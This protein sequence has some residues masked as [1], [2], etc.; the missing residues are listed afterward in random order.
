MFQIEFA[1][2]E[3]YSK[4]IKTW[5]QAMEYAKSLGEGWRLPTIGELKEAYE[6]NVQGFLSRNY[7]SLSTVG[8]DTS[9]VWYLNIWNG[10]KGY[11]YRQG[12]WD[13]VWV[14]CVRE[15]A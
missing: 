13:D 11:D 6:S 8:H 1:F 4:N 15:V 10:E 7:W 2:Y 12:S 5:D 14:R 3:I 9:R